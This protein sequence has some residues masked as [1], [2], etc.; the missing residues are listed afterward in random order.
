MNIYICLSIC[1]FS[2]TKKLVSCLFSFSLLGVSHQNCLNLSIFVC[3]LQTNTI[4]CLELQTNTNWCLKDT[5]L[6]CLCFLFVKCILRHPVLSSCFPCYD[7]EPSFLKFIIEYRNYQELKYRRE[8]KI[9]QSLTFH[10]P[11]LLAP[12]WF[13]SAE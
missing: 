13:I 3:E 2:N 9:Y 12:F 4:W 7:R 6:V 11:W 10:K 8:E 1:I 5:N